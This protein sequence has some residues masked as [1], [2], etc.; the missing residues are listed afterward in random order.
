MSFD[1]GKSP[2][3]KQDTYVHQTQLSQISEACIS[4]PDLDCSI[5]KDLVL[6]YHFRAGQKRKGIYSKSWM[7]IWKLY[8]AFDFARQN[9]L[10]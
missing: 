10:A 9:L 8:T 1:S 3:H 6:G 4:T 7:L 2:S 5:C